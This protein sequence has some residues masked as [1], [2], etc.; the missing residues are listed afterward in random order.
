MTALHLGGGTRAVRATPDL[1]GEVTVPGDKSITH[2]AVMLNAIARGTATVTGAG[3][4]ADCL[5]TAAC[6]RALGAVVRRRWPDGTLSD[7]LRRHPGT[8]EEERAGAVL[9]VEGAGRT[10]L[11]EPADVLD[12]GNSGT[13]SRLLSGI[14]AGQ[15]FLSVLTGDDS[16]RSRPMGRIVAPLRRLGARLEARANGTLLPLAVSPGA[17]RGT[18]LTMSV[19]SAQL[20]SC[21]LLAGLYA[22]GVTEIVQPEA[23]RDHTERLLGAQGAR[24]TSA[25][26]DGLTLRIEGRP[27][28]QAVDVAVPGDISSAAFWLVAAC[29][30]PRARVTVRGV[31]VNPSRTGLLDVLRDMG[32]KLSIAGERT[33]GGEPVADVTAE[34]SDLHG[35]DVGG[36]LIPRLIDEVPVLAV[37]AAVARGTTTIRDAAELRVKESDRLAAVAA[38]LGKLG[39]QVEEQPDG[40]TVRGG[41]LSGGEVESYGDHRMAMALAVAALAAAGPVFIRGAECVDV[42]YPPFWPDLERLAPGS[43]REV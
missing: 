25:G 7:D 2:R 28:L 34:S 35:V 21:L 19:A 26:E 13:T 31:G 14:L 15:P 42:S 5:S 32:A 10:G 17:L 18:Q 20:K 22:D 36:A 29:I 38:E 1:S 41:R 6:M 43:T 11:R 3:L 16:L 23:S 30:H 39:A 40:L 12:A 37:A 27:D 9:V 8:G 24:I 4:G 33:V